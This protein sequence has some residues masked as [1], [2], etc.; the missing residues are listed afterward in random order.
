ML[1]SP[2]LAT[3]A[4]PDASADATMRRKPTMTHTTSPRRRAQRGLIGLAAFA[5]T[6]GLLVAQHPGRADADPAPATLTWTGQLGGATGEA[7]SQQACDVDGNGRPDLVT[8]A[9]MWKRAP[10]GSIGAAYVIF[11]DARPGDLDDPTTGVMRIEGPL[12]SSALTGFSVSCAGDVNGDGFDDVLTTE[13]PSSRVWV[14]FGGRDRSSLS[15]EYLGDRGYVIQG[16]NAPNDRTGYQATGVGDLDGDGLDDL[17]ITSLTANN[18]GGMVSIVAGQDDIA[19]IDLA[20]S[21][22]VL[23]RLH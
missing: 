15:L 2:R 5:L 19:T 12:K 23:A 16:N 1:T 18:R 20:T 10:Q 4:G 3:A 14:V 17:A 13:Y 7:V 8:S 22:K 21:P 11:D 9:W 6:A